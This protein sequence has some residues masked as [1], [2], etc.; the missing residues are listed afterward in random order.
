MLACPR[1]RPLR[2]AAH[3]AM[4]ASSG[5]SFSSN[6]SSRSPHRCSGSSNGAAGLGLPLGLGAVVR[7]SG[8]EGAAELNGRT[9][10]V[11]SRPEGGSTSGL[12]EVV[13]LPLEGTPETEQHRLTLSPERL[14]MVPAPACGVRLRLRN[15]PSGYDT[16]LL[17]EELNDEGFTGEDC[18]TGLL[19][20]ASRGFC[21]L[22]ACSERIAM[23]I[24]GNFDGRRLE[25]CGPGRLMPDSRLA[26]IVK[27]ER[28]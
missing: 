8:L 22:T 6:S 20:D 23:Q 24:I 3:G 2:P 14:C 13:C 11:T 12:W 27:L 1:V 18:F 17:R 5:D 10:V 26:Q 28:L 4:E 19:H 25:R 21:Y 7:I 9:A 16:A 15:V